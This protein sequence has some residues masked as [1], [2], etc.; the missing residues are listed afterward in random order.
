MGGG[1]VVL[2]PRGL[3]S[4]LSQFYV[5][6]RSSS[7]STLIQSACRYLRAV[8]SKSACLH[9]LWNA[10]SAPRRFG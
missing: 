1:L 2:P 10:A 7:F 3:P 8:F 5:F 4:A 6:S 9:A